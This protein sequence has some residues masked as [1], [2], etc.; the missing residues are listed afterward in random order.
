MERLMNA[1]VCHTLSTSPTS[2][3]LFLLVLLILQRFFTLNPWWTFSTG[4]I[5]AHMRLIYSLQ[6]TEWCYY[7]KI[8]VPLVVLWG[9]GGCMHICS[10]N[11]TADL[12]VRERGI[13]RLQRKGCGRPL[14]LSKLYQAARTSRRRVTSD[15]GSA[16]RPQL[17]KRRKMS[18]E[19]DNLLILQRSFSLKSIMLYLA[20]L[21]R[22]FLI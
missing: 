18:T 12:A 2:P 17:R 5:I 19:D 15:C 3:T 9:C 14:C 16:G 22:K 8:N 10:H 6:N 1:P 21:L 13:E 4:H 11:T 20:T 7:R